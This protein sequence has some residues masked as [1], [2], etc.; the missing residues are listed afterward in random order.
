VASFELKKRR[1]VAL[2]VCGAL[3]LGIAVV[4]STTRAAA[5]PTAQADRMVVDKQ[6]HTLTL[7]RDGLV[8]KTYRVALGRGSPGQKTKAGDNKVPEGVY[9]IVG[10]YPR[11]SFYRALRVGYPT[12]DQIRE[13]RRRGIDPGGDIMVHG[14]RNGLGW[15]GPLQR[16]LDW[17][18]GC[19]GVTD[20]E[21]DEIWRLVPDVTP[22]EIRP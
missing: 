19:V 10:R 2:A 15:L 18:E 20:S 1:V 3:G 6:A 16:T 22:I 17:T 14:I 12:P 4:R 13:A 5:A 21:I 7:F 9:R 11:S 8:L